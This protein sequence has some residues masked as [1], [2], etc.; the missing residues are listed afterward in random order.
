MTEEDA[1]L[2]VDSHRGASVSVD[3]AADILLAPAGALELHA[4]ML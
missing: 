1:L 3:W 4:V 2:D